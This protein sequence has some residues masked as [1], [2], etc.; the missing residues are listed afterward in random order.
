MAGAPRPLPNE[1]YAAFVARAHQQLMPSVPDWR[2]R[3]QLV[4]DAWESATG[5][6]LRTVTEQKFSANK[7]VKRPDVCVFVENET[8]AHNSD[9]Q[10]ITVPYGLGE[11]ADVAAENN[12]RIS[13]RESYANIIEA[14]TPAVTLPGQVKQ[15]P[16]TLGY[17]GPI[18]LGMIGNK[19]PVF[20]LFADEFI[21]PDKTDRVRDVPN[22]SV[23]MIKLGANGRRYIGS[24]AAIS[25]ASR[26]PLPSQYSAASSHEAGEQLEACYSLAYDPIAERF[27]MFTAPGGLNSH[28]P[29]PI[30]AAANQFAAPPKPGEVVTAKPD[31]PGPASADQPP[32]GGE[33]DDATVAKIVNAIA[34]TAPFQF[35]GAVMQICGGDPTKLMGGQSPSDMPGTPQLPSAQPAAAPPA[36]TPPPAPPPPAQQHGLPNRYSAASDDLPT[37]SDEFTEFEDMSQGVTIEQYNALQAQTQEA[38]EQVAELQSQ[39]AYYAA[40]HADAL[41]R[42]KLRGLKS[43]YPTVDL[44][45]EFKDCLYGS[46]ASMSDDQ[47]SAHCALIERYASQ[48]TKLTPPLP[49]G[50]ISKDRPT[51]EQARATAERA[52]Y[53]AEQVALARK[54]HAEHVNRG[55]VIDQYTAYAKADEIL[56]ANQTN[57]VA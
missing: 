9:G 57:V 46:G 10:P 3:N 2:K 14:H 35:L 7:Y 24:L 32:S 31:N 50:E 33:V 8:V 38:M 4:W 56:R 5:D 15:Q 25:E 44:D 28:I 47:F 22:R 13:E 39:V 37:T 55:Q 12:L 41:R 36:P 34:S 43:K 23:E 17:M 27:S 20:G 11:L 6:D 29:S 48:V 49:G 42:E 26:L 30:P 18:R 53:S 40:E 54:I 21:R 19:Q 16:P 1:Q 52:Q 45:A 51:V